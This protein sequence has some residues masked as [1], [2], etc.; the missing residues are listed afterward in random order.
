MRYTTENSSRTT[1]SAATAD[2]DHRARRESQSERR[3]RR[4]SARAC[5]CTRRGYLVI[6]VTAPRRTTTVPARGKLCRSR[7]SG[8]TVRTEQRLK[9]ALQRRGRVDVVGPEAQQGGARAV[10]ELHV[11]LGLARVVDQD[12]LEPVDERRGAAGGGQRQH[13]RPVFVGGADVRH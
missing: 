13:D 11:D 10:A 5:V 3:G 4:S 2:A 9:V 12:L 1:T 6:A 8:E 7:Q